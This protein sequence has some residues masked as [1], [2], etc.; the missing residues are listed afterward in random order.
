MGHWI[1]S[2]KYASRKAALQ[3]REAMAT[4]VYLSSLGTHENQVLV[5][6]ARLARE[7]SI[8]R[9]TL[10]NH[11]K[12][13]KEAG[14]LVPDPDEDSESLNI[15]VWR[16]CPFIAWYGKGAK[17]VEYVK[18]LPPQHPFFKYIDPQIL[19]RTAQDIEELAAQS[20]ASE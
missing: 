3:L 19:A 12:K 8:S 7:L 5:R 18:G 1:A 2:Y 15:A 20:E 17:M 13:I 10:N 9:T 4:L 16:I 6:P 14:L 11:L